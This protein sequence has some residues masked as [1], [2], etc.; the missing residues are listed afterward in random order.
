ML[1]KNQGCG[2]EGLF[3]RTE[4]YCARCYEERL[5][6]EDTELQDIDWD[7]T[8]YYRRKTEHREEVFPLLAYMFA[9]TFAVV[10]VRVVWIIFSR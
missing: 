3:D 2:A 5:D 1:C 8:G 4:G 9:I 6:L 10:I 7:P